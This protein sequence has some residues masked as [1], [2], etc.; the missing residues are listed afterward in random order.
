VAFSP[1]EGSGTSRIVLKAGVCGLYSQ[2]RHEILCRNETNLV[3]LS[4]ATARCSG[5]VSK[6][7][8]NIAVAIKV[9]VSA[10]YWRARSLASEG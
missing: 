6:D 10:G 5:I 9:R 4:C 1:E 3:V 2:R 8:V 7:R